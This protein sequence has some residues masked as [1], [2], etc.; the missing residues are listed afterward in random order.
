[1]KGINLGNTSSD[2][3]LHQTARVVQSVK[4]RFVEVSQQ[5]MTV[6]QFFLR[7]D[8]ENCCLNKNYLDQNVDKN[9]F[10]NVF[11]LNCNLELQLFCTKCRIKV[12]F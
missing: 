4:P 11:Y 6:N 5:T 7:A 12:I 8:E 9:F 1:M 3:I 2:S 10:L